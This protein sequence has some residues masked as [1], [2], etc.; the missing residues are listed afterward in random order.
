[1]DVGVG[2]ERS[3]A[4]SH[5]FPTSHSRVA[6]TPGS[7][8]GYP[9]SKGRA[10]VRSTKFSPDFSPRP[11]RPRARSRGRRRWSRAS[12]PQATTR[13]WRGFVAWRAREA[14]WRST[15]M[16]RWQ[17]YGRLVPT[18]PNRP[19][20]VGGRRWSSTW[21]PSRSGTGTQGC[22]RPASTPRPSSGRCSQRCRHDPRDAGPR[23][24]AG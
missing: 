10:P 9:R 15:V 24:P 12:T 23:P 2:S 4:S 1:M 19:G 13:A 14:V 16:P 22:P 7:A 6:T 11:R 17:R 5:A 8:G 3:A 18:R 21:P 20:A